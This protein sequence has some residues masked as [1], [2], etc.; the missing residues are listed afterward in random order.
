MKKTR[1]LNAESRFSGKSVQ[2]VIDHVWN[3]VSRSL[4]HGAPCFQAIPHAGLS[5]QRVKLRCKLLFSPHQSK[6]RKEGLSSCF[7]PS[8]VQ[9]GKAPNISSLNW[10]PTFIY[11]KKATGPASF[12]CEISQFSA[13]NWIFSPPVNAGPCHFLSKLQLYVNPEDLGPEPCNLRS[14][15]PLRNTP[16]L[17]SFKSGHWLH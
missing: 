6:Q 12:T 8:P 1:L 10:S 7:Q 4:T 17:P 14:D 5:C 13:S 16:G 9:P 2:L 15:K 11:W 3:W